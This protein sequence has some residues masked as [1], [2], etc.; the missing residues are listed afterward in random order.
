[1][2]VTRVHRAALSRLRVLL[3]TTTVCLLSACGLVLTP[4]A[5]LRP[6][7]DEVL[8][9]PENF[10]DSF[11]QAIAEDFGIMAL[12]A[13]VVYRRDLNGQGGCSHLETGDDDFYG[14]PTSDSGAGR[15]MRWK[16]TN[17]CID[18]RDRG[19]FYETYVFSD[20]EGS[21][22]EAVIAFRGTENTKGQFLRDWQTNL[23]SLFGFEPAQY[24][25]ARE[26][27]PAVIKGLR[28]INAKIAIHAAG[29]SLGGGLA[30]QTGYQFPEVQTVVT[31]N[32]SPVTN[33]TRLKLES[34]VGN[35]YPLIYRIYHGGEI[36][37]KVRFITTSFT[38]TRFNRYDLSLQFQRK[39]LV[40]GHSMDIVACTLAR[41]LGKTSGS[42]DAGHHYGKEY[43]RQEVLSGGI[44]PKQ[45]ASG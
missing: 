11:V 20:A 3:A 39:S 42:G 44:C 33:W 1:M 35:R 14:M 29:H 17:A 7:D 21:P 6:Y 4:I 41:I 10:D 26:K 36:L 34:E 19:L 43:I 45:A 32:T 25:L 28:A 27:L 38:A 15:W 2:L 9:N 23:S 12:F 18:D 13:H 22:T 31:F 5:A 16:G 24:R 37:E 30:Q 8:D 40:S